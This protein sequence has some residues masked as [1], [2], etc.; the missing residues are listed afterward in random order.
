VETTSDPSAVRLGRDTAAA[1]QHFDYVVSTAGYLPRT[2]LGERPRRSPNNA[3]FWN[4]RYCAQLRGNC[5]P[6]G[7]MVLMADG[8]EKPIERIRPGDRVVSH[9]GSARPVTETF[10]RRYSGD[11][12]T[13]TADGNARP[14]TATADHRFGTLIGRRAAWTPAGAVRSG[15][16]L[17]G[18]PALTEPPDGLAV[19]DMK[20]LHPALLDGPAV[21][22][23]GADGVTLLAPP[24]PAACAAPVA[25][26]AVRAVTRDTYTGLRVYDIE[27]GTDHSFFANGFLAHNCTGEAFANCVQALV[28]MPPDRSATSAPLPRKDLSALYAYWQGRRYGIARGMHFQGDGGVGSF[29][30][31]AAKTTGI[32]SL[33]SYPPTDQN[34]QQ[35]SD[36]R[37]PPDAALREGPQHRVVETAII[38]SFAQV[39]DHVGAGFVAMVGMPIPEGFTQTDKTGRFR[40]TGQEVGGHEFTVV[41]YDL[42]KGIIIFANS[43]AN[44]RW[45]ALENH[46]D[47]DPRCQGFNNL[48]W[49]PIDELERWL[50]RYDSQPGAVEWL[51]IND[52]VGWAPKLKSFSD[53]Y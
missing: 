19:A 52:V 28:R 7:T 45:G 4:R 26:C 37:Q 6:A 25:P 49:C 3:A 22:A 46:P 42:D 1:V 17:I 12:V 39:L 32:A 14:V 33:E 53:A 51:A 36:N 41:D 16:R 48:G 23:R 2:V 5:F 50:Q 30:A 21:A 40:W 35:L 34:Y 38:P 18:S 11:V 43:W 24:P 20:T 27:V 15:A 29:V 10:R 31:F 13:V 8:T 44:A 9:T 47:Q